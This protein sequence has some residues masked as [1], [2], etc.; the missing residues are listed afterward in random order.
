[1]CINCFIVVEIIMIGIYKITCKHSGKFYIGSSLNIQERFKQH[2]N[3]L[4]KN[5]HHSYKLQSAYDKYGKDAF[6]FEVIEETSA[7]NLL[8][9]EQSYLDSTKSYLKGYNVSHVA[10]R[11]FNKL[12][13][14][15][16]EFSNE[17]KEINELIEELKLATVNPNVSVSCLKP[18]KV[19]SN[20]S[21]TLYNRLKLYLKA[22]LGLNKEIS[23]M[24]GKYKLHS[25]HVSLQKEVKYELEEVES[26]YS[27]VYSNF[28][29]NIVNTLIN[30]V[31]L[32]I[33]HTVE[34]NTFLYK[35]ELN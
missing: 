8:N 30:D 28:T 11:P 19:N 7:D 3:A 34:A 17:I 27:G 1:M 15:K 23:T 5:C 29:P 32:E 20:D 6:I 24:S 13:F 2:K 16:E 12:A 10:G 4:K 26:N 31:L 33:K 9:L 22:L 18:F 21:K 25:F 35:E 14:I